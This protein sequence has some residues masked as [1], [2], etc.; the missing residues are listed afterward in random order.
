MRAE[1]VCCE[2]CLLWSVSVVKC[3]CCEVC[4]FWSVSVL[5][6][7][8]KCVC[9][10]VKFNF[11]MPTTWKYIEELRY[12]FTL[13]L[14]LALDGC[15]WPASR[16]GRFFFPGRDPNIHWLR[17]FPFRGSNRYFSVISSPSQILIPP[18]SFVC[19]RTRKL[20]AV[21]GGDRVFVCILY[22]LFWKHYTL[23]ENEWSN[24][25]PATDS[26]L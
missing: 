1:C 10:E 8:V 23:S 4:L 19:D 16:T 2:V 24:L 12:C 5:E 14:T 7:V 20:K 18:P 9:F 11:S 3:V 26:D 15:E 22:S 21:G 6:C 25:W 17:S 13:S